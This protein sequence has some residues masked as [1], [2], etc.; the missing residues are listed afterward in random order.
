MKLQE[1]NVSL[2][3]QGEE[4]LHVTIAMVHRTLLYRPPAPSPA[5]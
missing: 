3:S 2:V 4:G 1:G 5:H